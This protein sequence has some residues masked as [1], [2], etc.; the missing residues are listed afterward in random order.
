MHTLLFKA[1]SSD[2]DTEIKG[3][4]DPVIYV[5]KNEAI[6]PLVDKE[7]QRITMAFDG[8]VAYKIDASGNQIPTHY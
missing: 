8:G 2:I 3:I 4:T 6:T 7:L 1:N 5:D